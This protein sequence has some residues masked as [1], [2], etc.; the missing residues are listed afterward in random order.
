MRQQSVSQLEA[1]KDSE[2]LASVAMRS[3]AQSSDM[4]WLSMID[5]SINVTKRWQS[6]R[7]FF[8]G[9]LPLE[10]RLLLPLLLFRGCCTRFLLFLRLWLLVDLLLLVLHLLS[11]FFHSLFLLLGLLLYGGH[12]QTDDSRFGG[13]GEDGLKT[14]QVVVL[15]DGVHSFEELEDVPGADVAVGVS[16]NQAVCLVDGHRLHVLDAGAVGLEVDAVLESAMAP[17]FDLS[18][19]G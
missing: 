11:H 4:L 1:E 3:R 6:L 14:F 17:H 15:A 10:L 18:L 13:D 7:S 8:L 9:G 2:Q 12:F 5:Y 16:S 19:F